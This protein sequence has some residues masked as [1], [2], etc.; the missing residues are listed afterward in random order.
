MGVHVHKF[1]QYNDYY[2]S[3]ITLV[4]VLVLLVLLLLK[5]D[6]K[7]TPKMI[8]LGSSTGRRRR[9]LGEHVL[10]RDQVFRPKGHVGDAGRTSSK[11]ICIR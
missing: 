4:L 7:S 3:T 8:M 9:F 5:A 2:H 11:K 10:D 6:A 1:G